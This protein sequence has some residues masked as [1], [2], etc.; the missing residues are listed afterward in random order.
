MKILGISHLGLAVRSVD[1][2][3][4]FFSGALGLPAG[5]Q[6]RVE[7]QRVQLSWHPVGKS[8]IE[9]LEPTDPSS[10]V[11]RFLEKRGE[12]IHHVCFIVEDI[13]GA[14]KELQAKGIRLIDEIPRKGAGGCQIAFLHPESTHGV[15]IELSEESKI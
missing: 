12:G 15:L 1:E 2:A 5:G 3:T 8:R 13:K 7:D 14:L 6:E 4:K 11:A 10:V 9:L